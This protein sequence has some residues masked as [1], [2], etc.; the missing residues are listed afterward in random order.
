MKILFGSLLLLL[1]FSSVLGQKSPAPTESVEVLIAGSVSLLKT[2]QTQHY[3]LKQNDNYYILLP[4]LL[5]RTPDGL[6]TILSYKETLSSVLLQSCKNLSPVIKN[7]QFNDQSLIALLKLYNDCV[8]EM[9]K[10]IEGSISVVRNIESNNFYL[11][12]KDTLHFLPPEIR[13][14]TDVGIKVSYPYKRV[15]YAVLFPAC[16]KITPVI[17]NTKL[18][19]PGLIRLLKKYYDCT[20][21]TST[22]EESQEERSEVRVGAFLGLQATH[23]YLKNTNIR[24]FEGIKFDFHSNLNWGGLIEV[25]S[26]K[27]KIGVGMQVGFT[28]YNFTG[29]ANYKTTTSQINNDFYSSY[30]QTQIRLYFKKYFST[31][32]INLNIRVGPSL[33]FNSEFSQRRTYRETLNSGTQIAF[34]EFDSFFREAKKSFGIHSAVG[35]SRKLSKT[36][37]FDFDV[38]FEFLNS[39]DDQTKAKVGFNQIFIT[40]QAGLSYRIK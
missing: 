29:E 2:R 30:S 3:Y 10:V 35:V 6:T 18:N 34:N 32:A 13:T 23:M 16:S 19:S 22:Y 20:G 14:L 37:T 12:K 24:S 4:P 39:M 40:P 36:I 31:D 11:L 9:E 17:E 1:S 7:V 5:Q 28:K 27:H 26:F 21:E 38:R 25:N 8:G 33:N 15:L